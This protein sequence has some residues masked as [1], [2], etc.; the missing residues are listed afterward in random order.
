M[1]KAICTV[2]Q[3]QNW[4]GNRGM[5]IRS[6]NIKIRGRWALVKEWY[7]KE[8]N[9]LDCYDLAGNSTCAEPWGVIG[10]TDSPFI[11]DNKDATEKAIVVLERGYA[12]YLAEIDS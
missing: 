1:D 7:S 6:N 9:E 8:D 11:P 5:E 2:A 4:F 10:Y 12:E 3:A